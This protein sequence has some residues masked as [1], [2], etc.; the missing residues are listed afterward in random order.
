MTD[1]DLLEDLAAIIRDRDPKVGYAV[2][3]FRAD[4]ARVV[5]NVGREKMEG[6][7]LD[8]VATEPTTADAQTVGRA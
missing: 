3:L 5:T 7:L 2:L 8:V 6:C 4:G 1:R